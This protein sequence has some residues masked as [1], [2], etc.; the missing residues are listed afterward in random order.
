MQ[1]YRFKFQSREKIPYA[2][3]SHRWFQEEVSLQDLQAIP[4]HFPS[5]KTKS[6][7]KLKESCR[8][9]RED[10]FEYIWND[11]CCIDKTN[12]AEVSEQIN[13]MFSYYAGSSVCYVYLDDVETTENEPMGVHG[14]DFRDGQWFKRGWTLQELLA[15]TCIIFFDKNWR[16]IGTKASLS[17]VINEVTRIP[18]DVLLGHTDLAATSIARRMSWAADRMTTKDEDIAY[19]LM[20]IFAVHMPVLYGEGKIRAFLRLQEEIIK[21]NND[22]TIFVWESESQDNTYERGSDH[23]SLKVGQD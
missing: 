11:T 5:Q 15:P 8:I 9:A 6:Y 22:P 21:Y 23:G 3:L 2:I 10:G 17:S 14:R 13:S 20:G 4:H 16:R 7:N 19:C 1:I 18:I 12:S